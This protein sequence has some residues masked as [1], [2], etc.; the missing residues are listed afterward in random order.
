MSADNGF[1]LRKNKE[2]KFVLQGYYASAEA[3]PLVEEGRLKFDTV[4]EALAKFEE[5][6][7]EWPSEYGLQVRL[8]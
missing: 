8:K 7:S 2:G 1:I 5:F 3:Y 6:E 4:E